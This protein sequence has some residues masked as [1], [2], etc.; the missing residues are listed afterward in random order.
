[1]L[2]SLVHSRNVVAAIALILAGIAYGS[3]AAQQG[4]AQ[5]GA[6]EERGKPKVRRGL[7]PRIGPYYL[8]MKTGEV[9]H[10]L[11][12]L[13]QTEK[14][15]LSLVVE[16]KNERIYHAPPAEFAGVSWDIVLGAVD[17]EVYKVSALLVLD[18]REERDGV[19]RNLEAVLRTRLGVPATAA[20]TIIS[21]DTEDGNVVVNR[22]ETGGAYAAVLTLTSRAVSGFARVPTETQSAQS[23]EFAQSTTKALQ[24]EVRLHPNNYEAWGALGAAYGKLH[25][26]DE[27]LASFKRV[28]AINPHSADA[29]LALASTYGFMGRTQEQ[30]DACKE[31]IKLEPSNARAH[32]TL[33][34]AY[35]KTGQYKESISASKEALRLQPDF[36]EAHYALGVAYLFSGDTAA[37]VKE[38]DAL[39]R[40]DPN[41]ATE[42]RDIIQEYKNAQ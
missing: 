15:A 42:F 22:A 31:A 9:H 37:A 33:G 27:A 1:M 29:Y 36:P 41:I 34:S 23:H 11:V 4:G 28:I 21:W 30:I 6:T 38:A 7:A 19:W 8:G 20:A 26:Y 10:Q 18:S 12:E 14:E 24:D 17:D 39:E 32:G 35:L 2:G 3:A 25:R 40:L 5:R 13:T 16:F